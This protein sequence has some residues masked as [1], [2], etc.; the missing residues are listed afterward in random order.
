MNNMDNWV[1]IGVFLDE[2]SKKKIKKIYKLPDGWTEYIDH[3]TV[4]FNDES[5][6]ASIVKDIC[7]KLGEKK[8][9]LKVIG[10]GL[11][12]KAYALKVE[13]PAG[14]PCTNH[15]SHITLACGLEGKPVDS[16]YIENWHNISNP[17]TVKGV[18]K[19]YYPKLGELFDYKNFC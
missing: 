1:Y 13:M 8:V 19:V 7:D 5:Y 18:L 12:D 15:I 4:A 11:S 9:E 16:N 17:F 14:I 2:K 3:M 10:Q 6:E